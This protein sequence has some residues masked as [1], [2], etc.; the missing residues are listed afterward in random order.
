MADRVTVDLFTE[1]V[2]AVEPRLKRAL[3]AAFGTDTGLDA[4]AYALAHGWEVPV[5]GVG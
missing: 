2:E 1:F 5:V 3:V 4:A